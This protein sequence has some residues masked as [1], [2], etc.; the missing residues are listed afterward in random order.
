MKKECRLFWAVFVFLANFPINEIVLG[1][2]DFSNLFFKM[3]P[4][5]VDLSSDSS[6]MSP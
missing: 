1:R 3:Y 2:H 4:K 6:T 5:M